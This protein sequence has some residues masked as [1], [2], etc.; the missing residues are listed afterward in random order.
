[1]SSFISRPQH[2][3]QAPLAGR[4]AL[5]LVTLILVSCGDV[6][7]PVANPVATPGGD[8]QQQQLALVVS[9]N[10]GGL[11]GTTEINVSGD[12]N[13]ATFVVG[14]GP[15][16]AAFNVGVFQA[17][18]A[19]RDGDSISLYSATTQGSDVTTILLPPGSAPVFVQGGVGF[20]VYEANSGTN[21]VGIIDTNQRLNTATIPVGRTPVALAVTPDGQK[22]Y[23][24]NQADGTVSVIT[25]VDRNVVTT[26]PVGTTPVWAVMRPDGALLYV[27]N[28]GSGTVSVIDTSTDTVAATV[29]VG[30]SPSHAVFEATL[31]RLYVANSGSDTVSV[32]NADLTVPTLLATVSVGAAPV[33]VSALA[34]GTR[35]YVANSGCQDVINL[36]NCSGNTVTVFDTGNFSVRKTITVGTTPVW[37]AAASDSSKVFVANRDSDNISDIRTL[38]DTVVTTI[39]A[40]APQPVF[41]VV[42]P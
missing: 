10:N 33:R 34:D 25:T 13:A 1:M 20:F 4:L 26:I 31:R 22:L 35:V 23:C 5:L 9:N 32:F 24:L 15:V 17:L 2:R 18:V 11:G 14:R 27:V 21:T 12:T 6:F 40:S 37:I 16:H 19:N 38:D 29:N 36:Q 41:V 28:R 3:N 39:A 42:G 30:A 8:P 7:R